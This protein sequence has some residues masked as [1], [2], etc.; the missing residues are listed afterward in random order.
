MTDLLT[1]NREGVILLV[2]SYRGGKNMLREWISRIRGAVLR[3]RMEEEFSSEIE[4]HLGLLAEDL[5]RRG[6]TPGEARREARGE[7]GGGEA[8]D[9]LHRGRR[10]VAGLEHPAAVL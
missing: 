8:S 10:G 9:G 2:T 3:R 5:V 6:M 4:A 1:F 7:V